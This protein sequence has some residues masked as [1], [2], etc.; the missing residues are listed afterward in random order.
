VAAEQL[1]RGGHIQRV[2]AMWQAPLPP[3][4]ILEGYSDVAQDGAE[5]VFR[6]FELEANHRRHMGSQTLRA[7]ARD[8]L[9][10]KFC[11]LIFV[12]GMIGASVYAIRLGYPVLAGVLGT[13]VLGTVVWAF[14]R[15]TGDQTDVKDEAKPS[16]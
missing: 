4:K 14:M 12:L 6:Q 9:I 10:G 7:Q 8:L 11:A 2:Q 3:P 15:V 16:R 13:G 5:R 1:P